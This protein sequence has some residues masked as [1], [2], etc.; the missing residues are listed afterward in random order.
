MTAALLALILC[1]APDT[2]VA[3][4][5]A[6]PP[7]QPAIGSA[8]DPRNEDMI[9]INGDKMP[10]ALGQPVATIRVG[11]VREGIG[12]IIPAQ[13]DERDAAGNWIFKSGPDAAEDTDKGLVDDNDELVLMA[14]DC[15]EKADAHA[16]WPTATA[17]GEIAVTDPLTGQQRFAYLLVFPNT[18]AAPSIEGGMDYVKYDVENDTI[19]GTRYIVGFP[20]PPKIS[21]QTYITKKEAGGNGLDI[22]DRFKMRLHAE[23][24]WGIISL[25][26]DES[27]MRSRLAGW[28]DGPVRVLRKMVHTTELFLGIESPE[29][30]GESYYFATTFQFPSHVDIPFELD[31]VLSD[32]YLHTPTDFNAN[33]LGMKFYSDRNPNGVLLDGKMDETEKSLDRGEVG[34]MVVSGEPGAWMNRLTYENEVPFPRAL[35][36]NDDTATPSPP[37]EH[38]GEIGCSGYNLLDLH[39]V[40]KGVYRFISHIYAPVGYK[41]GDEKKYLDIYDHPLETTVTTLTGPPLPSASTPAASPASDTEDKPAE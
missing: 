11:A 40:Q 29:V 23:T 28:T 7:A 5:T 12:R 24:M 10:V 31:Y 34:W 39:K 35:Y 38:P 30:V 6:T 13:V 4:A 25:T 14:M 15:G 18:D 41:P 36:Y 16:L 2:G 3:G 37:E 9:F 32:F 1:A 20:G 33:A 22:F 26:I 21:Y 17:V 27:D 8:E 19:E